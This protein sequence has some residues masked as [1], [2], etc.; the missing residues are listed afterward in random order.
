MPAREIRFRNL[1]F[2]YPATG[3]PVLAGPSISQIPAGFVARHR[4][5][6]RGGEDQHANCFVRL[7][8]SG[9]RAAIEIDGIDLRELDLRSLA[10]ARHG[11]VSGFHP[12]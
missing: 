8:A 7:Y 3:E 10:L 11:R 6:E 5:P 12:P 9:R 4:G 1:T 2:A